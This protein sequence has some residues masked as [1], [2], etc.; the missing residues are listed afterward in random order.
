MRLFT[1]IDI[2]P[3]VQRNLGALLD[4]L[5]PTDK[6][7]WTTLER[8]HIT[9]KF[10]GE[11]PEERIEE[12]KRT[13]SAVNEPGAMDIQ[14]RGLGW[15]PNPRHPRVFWAGVEGGA[16]LKALA[17]GIEETLEK[18]GV[19]REDREYSPHLTLARIRE[20]VPLNAMMRA[21]ESLESTDFGFFRATAFYLYLSR[22]GIYTK[23]AEFA[24]LNP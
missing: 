11:W 9:T 4:Q 3:G 16:A 12:M 6:L 8:M 21:I 15:F 2:A 24:L 7:S 20:R 22:S 13:L 17:R 23:L 18:I 19:P 1:A 5:R 10:I 14:I